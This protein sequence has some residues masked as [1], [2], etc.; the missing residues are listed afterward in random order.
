MLG[1]C[2]RSLDNP[3]THLYNFFQQRF[4]ER[5]KG[6]WSTMAKHGTRELQILSY[7]SGRGSVDRDTLNNHLCNHLALQSETARWNIH[8]LLSKGLII[9]GEDDRFRTAQPLH[10][11]F[12]TGTRFFQAFT[13]I[14]LAVSGGLS[15]Y[16]YLSSQFPALAI[17]LLLLSSS[18][19]Y[20]IS[21]LLATP[22]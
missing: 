3:L 11:R 4:L 10:I 7:I 18:M 12:S 15:A 13:W 1:G 20:V 19:I 5:H 8:Q 21:D 2:L 22:S 9:R 17:A 6:I 16:F 14:M